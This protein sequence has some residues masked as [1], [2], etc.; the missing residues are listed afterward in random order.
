MNTVSKQLV[1]RALFLVSA[2]VPLLIVT[3]NFASSRTLARRQLAPAKCIPMPRSQEFRAIEAHLGFV[4]TGFSSFAQEFEN[5]IKDRRYK[6]G[7]VVTQDGKTIAEEWTNGIGLIDAVNEVR[8]W[9]SVTART[10]DTNKA[11]QGIDILLAFGLNDAVV[12][13]KILRVKG[14]VASYETL[15]TD[16]RYDAVGATIWRCRCRSTENLED[17]PSKPSEIIVT[18]KMV[19]SVDEVDKLD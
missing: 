13:A 5:A 11:A 3:A 4:A 17:E 14:A 15:S 6:C 2:F 12:K 19:C 8:G 1:K 18:V 16:I 10:V 9:M 7:L